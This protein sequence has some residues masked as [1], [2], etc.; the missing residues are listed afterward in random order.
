[1][2]SI[3]LLLAVLVLTLLACL[4]CLVAAGCA[5]LA[6]TGPAVSREP[7]V[8]FPNL[9]YWKT[10]AEGEWNWNRPEED[11]PVETGR[12]FT[13][14]T[15]IILGEADTRE[16]FLVPPDTFWPDIP[17][18]NELCV[19]YA[20]KSGGK[21][22]LFLQMFLFDEEASQKLV[23]Q[24]YS[25]GRWYAEVGGKQYACPLGINIYYSKGENR[26]LSISVS[27]DHRG[28]WYADHPWWP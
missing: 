5:P 1:M 26:L 25:P 21:S 27:C 7:V 20:T 2:K 12:K 6:P 3:K 15:K 22:Y 18:K 4:L 9:A 8:T 16:I 14:K 17:S 28:R 19:A 10:K 23:A 13:G 11:W 24:E